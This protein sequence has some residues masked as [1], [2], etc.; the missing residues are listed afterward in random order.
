MA[1]H[2]QQPGAVG[3]VTV[4]GGECRL[5]RPAQPRHVAWIFCCGAP[6]RRKGCLWCVAHGVAPAPDGVIRQADS[7]VVDQVERGSGCARRSPAGPPLGM[8]RPSRQRHQ[9]SHEL[10]A[11][12]VPIETNLVEAPRQC[13]LCVLRQV[14]QD[15]PA[16]STEQHA[17]S[18]VEPYGGPPRRIEGRFGCPRELGRK[19]CRTPF[20]HLAI[21]FSTGSRHGGRPSGQVLRRLD[22]SGCSISHVICRLGDIGRC[23]S[24]SGECL[25]E[26]A[27]TRH[28][29]RSEGLTGHGDRTLEAELP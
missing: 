5:R 23:D 27:R 28:A 8:G 24:A 20:G 6:S 9:L 10:V 7:H 3:L 14:R 13:I 15:R 18:G 17:S 2:G 26:V 22:P 1:F 12:P 11:P 21:D 19:K 4:E 16:L 29:D 25:G